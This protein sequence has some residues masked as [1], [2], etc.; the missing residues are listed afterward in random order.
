MRDS[1]RSSD[2]DSDSSS[3]LK[4]GGVDVM[5]VGERR[6]RETDVVESSRARLAPDRHLPSQLYLPRLQQPSGWFAQRSESVLLP[7]LI[8]FALKLLLHFRSSLLV[9]VSPPSVVRPRAC[10]HM[11]PDSLYYGFSLRRWLLCGS[12][13]ARHAGSQS[14]DHGAGQGRASGRFWS[15]LFFPERSVLTNLDVLSSPTPRSS[16]TSVPH[17]LTM[18]AVQY[19]R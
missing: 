4:L 18:H 9:S 12:G 19:Q 3:G 8:W 17:S 5:V 13:A 16:S 6:S 11:V 7:E 1:D 10:S 2:S 15:S 14:P